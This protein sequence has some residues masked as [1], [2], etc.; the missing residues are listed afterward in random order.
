MWRSAHGGAMPSTVLIIT[1]ELD[2]HADAVVLELHRRN[3]PVFRFHPADFPH[4]CSISIEIQDGRV[5]GDIFN[6]YHRV[7]FKDICAAWF[8]R[9]QNLLEARPSLTST[10]LDNYVK[11]QST[12]TLT[13]LYENLQTLWVSHPR[14][15]R[16][17]EV[18]ALQLAEAS[19]AGLKTPHTLISN[20]PA[21][22]AAFVG[23][24]GDTDCAV[25]PLLALGVSDEQGYHFPLTTTLPKGHSLESV[26]L[27]PT[28]FQPYIDK[29][30][31]LRCVVIGKQIFCAKIN[32][33]AN[34]NTR[35]DWRAGACEHEVFSLPSHVEASIH[36]LMHALDINFAS[37]DM[38]LTP[39]GDIVFLEANPNGQWLWLEEQLGLPL[40]ASM[41]DLLTTHYSGEGHHNEDDERDSRQMGT[42]AS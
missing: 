25:K 35:K 37:M 10:K 1:D 39:E 18:K 33:Q 34:E 22:A 7:A 5:E 21:K 12:L 9:S 4:A 8:R 23:S 41:V 30:A 6:Q 28:I 17:A 24:L 13:T 14:K 42:L 38:I 26:A 29:A 32:S 15:L 16:R 20:D 11:A 40:V 31:E 19:K 3:V 27:A 36:R 2:G